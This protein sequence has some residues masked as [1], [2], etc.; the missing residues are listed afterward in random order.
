MTCQ[1]LQ[2]FSKSKC[3]KKLLFT[4]LQLNFMMRRAD[5][6]LLKTLD[7]AQGHRL[8]YFTSMEPCFIYSALTL[9]YLALLNDLFSS[10]SG[11]LQGPLGESIII[12]LT[13]SRTSSCK[14]YVV[15]Y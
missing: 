1:D 5:V 2:G 6:T 3:K 10:T 7:M 13:K 11:T 4:V 9:S 12:G 8:L 15:F 14:T